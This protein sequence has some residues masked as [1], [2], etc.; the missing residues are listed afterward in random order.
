[1]E[2]IIENP[3]LKHIAENVFLNLNYEKLE[4]CRL[5][6]ESCKEILD[7]PMFW[8]KKF[9]RRGLSKK[10][11]IDWTT[12]I[13]IT[14]PYLEANI[15]KYLKQSSKNERVVDIPC[16]INEEIL[17]SYSQDLMELIDSDDD[18]IVEKLFDEIQSG[19]DDAKQFQIL[20]LFMDNYNALNRLTDGGNT[21]IFV[22]A[23]YENPQIIKILA[24]LI[25]N[26]NTTNRNGYNAIQMSAREGYTEIV[27]ILVPL[28]D[29]PNAPDKDGETPIHWAVLEGHTEIVKILVPFTDNLNVPNE[30]GETPIYC[31]A[32]Y[33]YTKIVKILAPLT[34]N[35]NAPDKFGMTPIYVAAKYGHTEIVKILARLTDNPNAPDKDGWTPYTPIQI[36]S[37]KGHPE[38]VR[39]LESFQKSAKRRRIRYDRK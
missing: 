25:E 27:K 35:P 22:A 4:T 9:I 13:Q 17:R 14:K 39:I 10:N 15:L 8:I 29:N 21:Y 24:P 2:D 37:M 16:H 11:Q 12:A 38:I 3:G 5:V 33:G 18:Q 34:D 32:K 31:A 1:M 20:A 19:D 28:T 6:N 36:A 7:N 26:I 30:Y 23:L